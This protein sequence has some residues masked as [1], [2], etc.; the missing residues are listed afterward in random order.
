MTTTKKVVITEFG[1]GS[2]LVLV[3]AD[4]PPPL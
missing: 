4:L 1:D 2:K 3:D